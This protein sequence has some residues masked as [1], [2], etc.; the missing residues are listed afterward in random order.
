MRLKPLTVLLLT[1]VA[2]VVAD[3][4]SKYLVRTALPLH[5]PVWIVPGLLALDHV[6][7]E[8]AAFSLLQGQ[9]VFFIVTALVVLGTIS[10]VW[11]RYRPTSMWANV[12]LGLV[13]GGAVGNLVDRAWRGTVTDFIDPRVFP[14]FNVADSAI[15]VGVAV[16]VVWLIFGQPNPEPPVPGDDAATPLEGGPAPPREGS[17]S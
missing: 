13:A 4:V 3:Q 7:N 9:R 12:A 14:V 16:L 6:Q 11:W 5:V 15:V 2:A 8:G 1:A 17:A 10:Y